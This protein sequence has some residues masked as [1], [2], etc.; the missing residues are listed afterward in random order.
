MKHR[1][2]V[3]GGNGAGK[4]TLGKALASKLKWPFMDIE[5]YYF[6]EKQKEY[7]YASPKDRSYVEKM[8]LQDMK[9]TENFVLAAV[10]GNYGKDIEKM[11]DCAVLIC[12]NKEKRIERVINRSYHK[13]GERMMPGGDLYESENAF[14]EMIKKRSDWEVEEWL[15]KP[16][17]PTIEV[18]GTRPVDENVRLILQAVLCE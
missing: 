7:F 1:I 17:L 12:V 4:S 13:F 3:C 9:R 18:A 16:Q 11:F 8:L 2:I 14:F 6:P 15:K 5:D 10:K